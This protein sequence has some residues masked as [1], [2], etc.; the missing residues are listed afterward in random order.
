MSSSRKQ[1][2]RTAFEI[3]VLAVSIAAVALVVVG[4][5]VAA[6]G[7]GDGGADLRAT[8]RATGRQASG[9]ELYEVLIRNVG[10]ETAENVVIEVTLGEETRELE[11]LSVSKGDEE[12]ATIVFPLG[13]SGVASVDVLSYHE[14]TRG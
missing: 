2:R 6:I 8:V 10:D 7:G 12:K 14:T 1:R 11:L 4:L 3:A 9:G 5:I 13:A